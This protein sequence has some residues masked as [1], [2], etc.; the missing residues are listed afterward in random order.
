LQQEEGEVKPLVIYHDACADGWCSA[1]V[2]RL[3]LP[4]AEF[5]AAQYGQDPPHHAALSGRRIYI[6]D[7]SYKRPV[8]SDMAQACNRITILDHHKTA[9]AELDGLELPGVSVTFDMGKS[10]AMLTWERFFPGEPPPLLVQYV[11]DRDLWKWAMP[12]SREVS[13]SLASRP[14]TFEEWNY[15]RVH[16]DREA[17]LRELVAEGK[18]I[19]RYQD[20]VVASHVKNAVP[21]TVAGH[22]IL[23]V[24]STTLI[25]E[26]AGKL[27][28]G[29]PFGACY[30]R[31]ADGK[32]VWSLRS[33]DGG[34]DVSEI[35]KQFGGGGHRAA[36]GFTIDT[37]T[38][39]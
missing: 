18:A 38:P 21:V 19:L 16:M 14:W 17:G 37:P 8:I 36:A 22:E 39:A 35:A 34:V 31:R 5:V 6:V 4:D 11:Q 7:F 3:G 12:D 10:G 1:W 13:A 33:R 9:Q 2:A 24:N 26:I 30:F 25:S 32:F 28:E 20:G 23:A 15:L 27:A 29:M